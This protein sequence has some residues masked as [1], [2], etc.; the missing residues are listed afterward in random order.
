MK[1]DEVLNKVDSEL[2]RKGV[3]KIRVKTDHNIG[4]M[5]GLTGNTIAIKR[6]RE[7]KGL[8]QIPYQKIVQLAQEHDL[9][10]NRIFGIKEPKNKKK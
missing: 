5:L 4:A 3:N 8:N 10:L 7:K 1:L 2:F 6:N 9:D